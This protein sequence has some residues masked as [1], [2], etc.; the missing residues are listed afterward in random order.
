[1]ETDQTGIHLDQLED[2]L[3]DRVVCERYIQ[4]IQQCPY[5]F[6]GKTVATL[7][8]GSGFLTLLCCR[9]GAK[10]VYDIGEHDYDNEE[11]VKCLLRDNGYT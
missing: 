5:L 2:T 7:Y 9:A 10:H 6:K 11:I 1:M 3:K 4:A 8:S